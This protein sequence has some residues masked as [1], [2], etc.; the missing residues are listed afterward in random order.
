M[1]VHSNIYERKIFYFGF[2][3]CKTLCNNLITSAFRDYFLAFSVSEI[4]VKWWY[5]SETFC[6]P[7][8]TNEKENRFRNRDPLWLLSQIGNIFWWKV[9][10]KFRVVHWFEDKYFEFSCITEAC[11][12][13]QVI[14]GGHSGYRPGFPPSTSFFVLFHT[15]IYLY[16]TVVVHTKP[17]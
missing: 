12:R 5:I 16:T 4:I 10:Y 1:F 3:N 8:T 7:N 14:F 11:V 9:L 2:I 13:S 6:M 17:K 15:H